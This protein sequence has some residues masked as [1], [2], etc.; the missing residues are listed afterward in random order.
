[1]NPAVFGEIIEGQIYK[2]R[3]SVYGLLYDDNGHI[4]IIQTPRGYFLPGGGIEASE[5]HEECL[6]RE[7]IEE[8]GY[9]VGIN[10]YIGCGI[11]YG[12][13]PSIKRYLKMVGH[14]YKVELTGE[15]KDKVE[16]DHELVWHSINDVEAIMKLENQAWA[17]GISK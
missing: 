12:F 5:T 7:F 9:A 4:A 1:M 16:E 17:I 10:E 6:S 2:E 11:L 15:I 8:T 14:F 13:A 3:E